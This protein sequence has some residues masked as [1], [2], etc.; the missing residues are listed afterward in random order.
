MG[1]L[2]VLHTYT[3]AD[4]IFPIIVMSRTRF[5]PYLSLKE[6]MCGETSLIFSLKDTSQEIRWNRRTIVEPWYHP[7]KFSSPPNSSQRQLTKI[8]SPLGHLSLFQN[9][10]LRDYWDRDTYLTVLHPI[11]E[12]LTSACRAVHGWRIQIQGFVTR[13]HSGQ[14]L[15]SCNERQLRWEGLSRRTK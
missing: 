13:N 9:S 11:S 5:R 12:D 6:P 10:L 1:A 2:G 15:P 7:N 14:M 4:K 8:L 3:T